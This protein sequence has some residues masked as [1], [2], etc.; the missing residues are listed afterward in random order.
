MTSSTVP[1]LVVGT[2]G[3]CTGNPGPTGWAYICADGRWRAG[4]RPSGTN[5]VGELMAVLWALTDF[6]DVPLEIES[7][8]T[9]AIGCSTTWKAG[10]QRINYQRAKPLSNLDIIRPIHALLDARVLPVCFTKVK[11][12]HPDPRKHPLNVIAD[13]LATGAVQ[14]AKRARSAVDHS[15]IRAMPR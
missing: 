4:G 11:G 8:S 6:A 3:A 7:D 14:L 1:T 5:Q 13:E 2:D 15:G 10:W 9:Y 12:H